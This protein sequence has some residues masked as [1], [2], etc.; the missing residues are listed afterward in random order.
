MHKLWVCTKYGY[1][2]D[3]LQ[4]LFHS[5]IIPLFTYGISVWGVA[6]YEKYLSKID[7]FQTRTVRFGFLKEGHAHLRAPVCKNQTYRG[8]GGKFDFFHILML[9]RLGYN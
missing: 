7:K 1:S 9:D 5:L 6:S 2:L 3:S 8:K 4:H